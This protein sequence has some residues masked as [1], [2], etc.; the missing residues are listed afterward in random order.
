MQATVGNL[1]PFTGLA[2]SG[3]DE[4]E[5][6]Y[7]KIRQSQ[8]ILSLFDKNDE[9]R[10]TLAASRACDPLGSGGVRRRTLVRHQSIAQS[11]SM[12][13]HIARALVGGL[14][15]SLSPRRFALVHSIRL[16]FGRSWRMVG[17]GVATGITKAP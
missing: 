12:P 8:P 15:L 11:M 9:G 3:S 7:E 1:N 16:H 4:V 5:P 2:L 13:E 14:V 10:T 6:F 17:R